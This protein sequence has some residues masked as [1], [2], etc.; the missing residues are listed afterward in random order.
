MQRRRQK[1][2][3]VPTVRYPSQKVLLYR[4]ISFFVYQIKLFLV[5]ITTHSIYYTTLIKIPKQLSQKLGTD[6]KNSL[7]E[8]AHILIVSVSDPYHFDADPDPT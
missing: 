8:R 4:F 5:K 6:D 2:C 1:Y 3:L 7:N